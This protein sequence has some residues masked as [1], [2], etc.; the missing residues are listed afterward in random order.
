MTKNKRF[1]ADT[2][3]SD[4]SQR[5]TENLIEFDLNLSTDEFCLIL[6]CL[7]QILNTDLSGADRQ[8]VKI[9][10]SAYKKLSV[11]IETVEGNSE[12]THG[13]NPN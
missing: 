3:S 5:Q 11:F 8:F 10:K 7:E 1:I 4:A 12:A 2:A 9:L 13:Q 6:G